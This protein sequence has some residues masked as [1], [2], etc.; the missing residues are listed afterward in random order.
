MAFITFDGSSGTNKYLSPLSSHLI[1]SHPTLTDTLLLAEHDDKPYEYYPTGQTTADGRSLL[2]GIRLKG[3]NWL[4]DLWECNFHCTIAQAV[5]FNTL[6][7][8]QQNNTSTILLTDNWQS[9]PVIKQ[10]WLN[11][12]R[13]YLTQVGSDWRRLQFQLLEV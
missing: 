7:T 13:Q 9:T 1:L 8:A 3:N 12:D 2:G 11:V 6:I 10:I 4:K 5:L